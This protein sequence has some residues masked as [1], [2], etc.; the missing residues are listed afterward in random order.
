[1]YLK[2]LFLSLKRSIKT[3]LIYIL[4]LVTCVTLF[5]SFNSLSSKFYTPLQNSMFDLINLYKYLT[6]FSIGIS[7]I[8]SIL[9][10]Y[11]TK[12][13]INQRKRELGTYVLMGMEQHKVGAI[14]FIESL[15]IGVISI[16]IGIILG[17]VFAN[18]I[19]K[20]IMDSVGQ[21][22]TFKFMLYKDTIIDTLI[23]F[24]V[25]FVLVG[26][27]NYIK[28][29]KI[30]LIKLFTK[31]EVEF[32][33]NKKYK[34]N[35]ILISLFTFFIP[36]LS[37]KTYLTFRESTSINVS[38]EV[39][40]LI[41]LFLGLM[42]ILGIYNIFKSICGFVEYIKT[43]KVNIRYKGLN[44]IIFNSILSSINKYSILMGSVTLTL[45]LSLMAL[46]AG[47]S[48]E[49]WAKGYLKYR[50]VYD[51]DVSVEG[52][53]PSVDMDYI[54]N[55][56]KN[57]IDN[58]NKKYSV[59]DSVQVE[60]YLL[61]ESNIENFEE[62]NFYAI[63]L[64]DYN[65]MRKMA[66]HS[67]INLDNNKFAVQ[68]YMDGEY[69]DDYNDDK[70]IMKDNVYT[71]DKNNFYTDSVGEGVY[72][73]YSD[74]V[75]IL[76]DNELEGLYLSGL[77]IYANTKEVISYKGYEKLNEEISPY[78]Q[79]IIIS[80]KTQPGIMDENIVSYVLVSTK[81]E[82]LNNSVSGTLLFK[83]IS[84]YISIVL[85]ISSL[86]IISLHILSNINNQKN[87]YI[88]LRKLGSDE[89]D[90]NK[91][92]M[93]EVGMYFNI[94]LAISLISTVIFWAQFI[95][96]NSTQITTFSSYG[97]FIL[98]ILNAFSII[99]VLY[100]CYFISTYKLF[101]DNMR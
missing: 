55:T 15:A 18:F 56:Y 79:D 36:L 90:L 82:K 98:N 87:R 72:S 86:T 60:E 46:S 50:D 70:I 85:F 13:I 77:S 33:L 30:N 57:I 83:L 1:M 19:T 42:F 101:K 92:I 27:F 100:L 45:T 99:V 20:I 26:I 59:T 5:Y 47:F 32:S 21:S 67:E 16:F 49:S 38:I 31:N 97:E 94:P 44:L 37:V 23:F 76:P 4:T 95:S 53:R 81:S 80:E 10:Y 34:K 17:S 64:S 74:K 7:I 96:Y 68:V 22:M 12:F 91:C 39:R 89:N 48:M 58:I 41:G 3:Y 43:N 73:Y 93:Y 66:G 63:G 6:M 14:F 25:L 51:F 8:L 24:T 54:N 62:D 65:S 52:I 69:K 75:I 71:S 35:N 88:M 40:N 28:I 11:V 9:I 29:S 61:N 78:Y 84:I 2:F